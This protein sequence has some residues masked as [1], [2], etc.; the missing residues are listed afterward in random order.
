MGEL[1]ADEQYIASGTRARFRLEKPDEARLT[2]TLTMNAKQWRHLMRQMPN[3][4]SAAGQ[5]G[6]MIS[7]MLSECVGRMEASYETTG[8]SGAVMIEPETTNDQ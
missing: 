1:R 8:W 6:K 5:I 7:T 2:F 4:G 3:D